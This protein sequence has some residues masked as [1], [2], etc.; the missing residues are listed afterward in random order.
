[1]VKVRVPAFDVC[2]QRVVADAQ[3]LA[4]LQPRRTSV[5]ETFAGPE[6]V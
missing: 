5:S 3:A 4:V 1:M 2:D 6:S